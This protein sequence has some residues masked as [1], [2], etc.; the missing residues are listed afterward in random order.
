MKKNQGIS[1][2]ERTL[3]LWVAGGHP[4]LVDD[5]PHDA[6]GGLQQREERGSQAERDPHHR[7]DQLADQTLHDVRH[8]LV[9]LFRAVQVAHPG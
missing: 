3:T 8:R 4:D 7:C 1:F 6:E 2:F 5:L 9:L